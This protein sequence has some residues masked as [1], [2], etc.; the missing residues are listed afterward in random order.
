MTTLVTGAAGFIGSRLSYELIKQGETVLGVDNL[1]SY[2]DVN[3][4][5]YRLEKLTSN[6]LFKFIKIDLSGKTNIQKL[7][8]KYNITKIC[9]LAAQAG[10]RYSLKNPEIYIK[11]NID[12]FLKILEICRKFSNIRLVYASSSSVYGGNKK[13]PFAVSDDVSNPVSLY[14]ATKRSNELMAESY[15]NLF[16]LNIIG[17]RFFTVY[18]PW[19]RPDMAI[20]MFTEAMLKGKKINVF[21]NGILSRDFTYIDDIVKGVT[22]ALNYKF[23][24]NK[25]SHYIFNLGNNKPL[26]VNKMISTLEEILSVKARKN[27]LPM[28]PGDVKKTYADIEDSRRHLG[29]KPSIAI[30]EGLVKF[31]DW[32]KDYKKIN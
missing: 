5:K 21:N 14:A 9:H 19:G 26:T 1:N 32:Y 6:S 12:G 27:L 15:S 18:G 11:F 20:W 8:E 13:V 17:L 24:G 3:L 25:R 23:K 30:R 28:Q 4:K 2:Y 10:V 31:T 29:F 16:K 7:I 22:A